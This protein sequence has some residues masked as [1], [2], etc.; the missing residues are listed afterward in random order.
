[1]TMWSIFLGLDRRGPRSALLET[2][3]LKQGGIEKVARPEP[4]RVES[5][6]KGS[7]GYT[8]ALQ[9]VDGREKTFHKVIVLERGVL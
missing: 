2:S 7:R 3:A 8:V 9:H 1:M 6:E 4:R 5:I